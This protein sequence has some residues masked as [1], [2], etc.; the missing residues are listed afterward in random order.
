[1]AS[2]EVWFMIVTSWFS[3]AMQ[4]AGAEILVPVTVTEVVTEIVPLND[5][6]VVGE[7]EGEG[8]M[9]AEGEKDSEVVA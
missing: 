2:D 4:P 3:M 1:V 6:E 5:P 9:E 8:E 7:K